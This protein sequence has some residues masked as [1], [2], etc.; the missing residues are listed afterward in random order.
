MEDLSDVQSIVTN[1]KIFQFRRVIIYVIIS[2]LYALVSFQRT[3]PSVVSAEMAKDYGI[4]KSKLSIFSSIFFYPYGL[5]QP[6]AGLL[7]DIMEPSY[8]IGIMQII[9]GVG[10]IIC[11]FSKNL[12]TGCVGRFLVGLGCGPT[13]VAVCRIIL[14]WFP[15]KY[16]S[17]MIGITIA[18][19]GCGS[20]VSQGPLA[21]LG[22]LIGWR[23]CFYGIGGL[24]IVFSILCLIF[25]RG[26]PTKLNFEPVN[27]DLASN[28][29]EESTLKEK[30]QILGENFLHVVKYPWFWVV[31]VY[32]VFAN[33]PF[34]DISGMW[35]SP[36]LQDVLGYSKTKAGNTSIAISI[37]LV[38]GSLLIPPLSTFLKTRKWPCFVSSTISFVVSIVLY[39]VSKDKINGVMIYFFLIFIGAFTNSLTSVCYP[40]VREYFHPSIAGTAV[41][42]AN[43][44]TFLSSAV[45]QTISSKIIEKYGKVVENGVEID[46]YTEKGY[47]QG[48]WLVSFIS[49]LVSMVAIA[50]TKDTKPGAKKGPEEEIEEEEEH[51]AEEEEKGEIEPTKED[52][53]SD[54]S[55]L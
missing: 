46:K 50:I 45:Y 1:G 17:I 43:I 4:D 19:G 41:G 11:G 55:E 44:F 13:Y 42:C 9:S 8:V 34:F 28:A 31:V 21:T 6:F 29:K 49:F 2:I 23:N 12:G 32:A 7:S 51:E 5:V 26:D 54:L 16:Y 14:A 48:L 33:G 35:V 37:G 24:G 52:T 20:I 3:C 39:L 22:E 36:Y 25:V 53:G 15:L 47:K 30:L 40:L 18:I 27:K 10:A 38:I